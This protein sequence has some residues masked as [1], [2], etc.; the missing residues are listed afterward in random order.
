MRHA[1][2]LRIA[3]LLF[4]IASSP[5]VHAQFQQ[6]TN[7][8]LKMTE[9][10]KAPGAAAVYLNIEEIDDDPT[11]YQSFYVRIKVLQEKG[12]ELA[13]V[14]IPYL[15]SSFKV[16]DIKARTIHSDGSVIPLEGKGDDLLELKTGD[17][18]F[19]RKVFTLPGV[20]VG[21]ILEYRYQ[22]H[23]DDSHYSS[24]KWQIQ[25]HYFIHQ[26]HYSFK[27][28][29]AFM[30][31]QGNIP[32]GSLVDRKGAALTSLL[33]SSLLPP[34]VTLKSDGLGSL[35]VDV[36]DVPPIPEEEWMPPIQSVLYKVDFYYKGAESSDEFWVNES[37]HWAKDVDHLAE[38]TKSLSETVAALVAANDSDVEK[39]RKI[40]KAVQSLDNT[41]FSRAKSNAE[42]KRMGFHPPKR[43]EDIWSQKSGSGEEI[44]LLYLAMLRSAGLTAYAMRVV[45][46]EVRT[47]DP[48]Y[49][50]FDQFD[51]TLVI[52]SAGGK[53][54][55]LDPSEKMCP[56][57]TLHWRHSDAQG[58]RQSARGLAL[59]ATP[60]QAYGTNTKQRTGELK[61]DEHGVITGIVNFEITGQEALRWRQMALR[62]DE[63]E[64]KK[65]FD[66][67]LKTLVSDGIELNIDRFV[68]LDNPDMNL[69]AVIKVDGTLGT[70]TARRLMLPGF[71]LESHAGHPFINQEKRQESVDMHYAERVS[72]QIV[73]HL[74]AGFDVEGMPQDTKIPW[75]GHAVLVTRS[76]VDPQQVTIARQFVRAFTFVKPEEYKDLRGFYQKVAAA[77]QQEIVL[78]SSS[79]AKNN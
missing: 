24:P 53:E 63:A 61:V 40:Y 67:G 38:P 44:A 26:A 68:A 69:L 37:K 56:F 8:E 16:S 11:H 5:L 13:T 12:K 3:F 7:E 15:K 57:E 59:T 54:L 33:W 65:A 51:D 19:G 39:A 48:S 41:D 17:A 36:N 70:F 66:R 46:R 28:F 10:P 27:P 79:K 29:K 21:S 22:I 31:S 72:D 75:E 9:D 77:D 20:E 60:P 45:D 50:N 49:L 30:W 4:T 52:L 1:A 76:K 74:P 58:V 55:F 34:G 32:T 71:F 64:V 2:S 18:Q 73:Y 35:S 62:N 43:A 6:P 78:E 23:Y 14:E 47:F 25:R 42:M